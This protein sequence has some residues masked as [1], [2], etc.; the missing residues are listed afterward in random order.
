MG[1]KLLGVNAPSQ[2]PEATALRGFRKRETASGPRVFALR[3]TLGLPQRGS[4]GLS[5]GESNYNYATKSPV[6]PGF[7][8]GLQAFHSFRKR[9]TVVGSRVFASEKRSVC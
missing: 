7:F 3:E 9:E 5:S 1:K 2:S 8:Y 6:D 4:Q